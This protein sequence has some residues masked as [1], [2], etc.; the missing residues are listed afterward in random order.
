MFYSTAANTMILH[1]FF[2]TVNIQTLTNYILVHQPMGENLQSV[3]IGTGTTENTLT[4]VVLMCA[5]TV[6]KG[7]EKL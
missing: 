5:E 7:Y 6:Q 1:F 2:S 3:V 4:G